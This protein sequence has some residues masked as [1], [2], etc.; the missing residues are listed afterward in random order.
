MLLRAYGVER[1]EARRIAH[2]RAPTMPQISLR[3][4]VLAH[5]GDGDPH[6]GAR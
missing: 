3:S 5:L 1:S 2:S 6:A 4:A